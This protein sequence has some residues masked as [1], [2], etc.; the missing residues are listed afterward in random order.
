MKRGGD[1]SHR[2][3]FS[4]YERK[5][6]KRRR[7]VCRRRKEKY[8]VLRADKPN[9]QDRLRTRRLFQLLLQQLAIQLSKIANCLD[10]PFKISAYSFFK[11]CYM[12]LR[13]FMKKL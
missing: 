5:E 11:N 2:R 8:F 7:Q 4:L 3:L 12:L 1:S 13:N 10:N 6:E 9:M